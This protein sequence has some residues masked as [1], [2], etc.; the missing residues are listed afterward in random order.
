V[1]RILAF[2]SFEGLPEELPGVEKRPI[3]QKNEFNMRYVFKTTDDNE[4]IRRIEAELPDHDIPIDW[5]K[6]YFCDVLTPRFME[7]NPRPAFWVDLDVDLYRSALDVLGFMF[8]NQLIGPG[9]LLSYDDWGGTAEYK[10]GES[11][12]HKEMC[13]KYR[14]KCRDVHIHQSDNGEHC[15][16]V[17]LVESIE[18]RL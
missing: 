4:I 10:G 1:E 15:Q 5:H 14:A 16:R 17:F 18:G 2:D 3:W 6:G 7:T 11:L 9:C 13:E 12:A 8:E